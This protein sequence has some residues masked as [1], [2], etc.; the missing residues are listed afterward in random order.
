MQKQGA[1]ASEAPLRASSSALEARRG[2]GRRSAVARR[3][4][5]AACP[6][7]SEG[8]TRHPRCCVR[9]SLLLVRLREHKSSVIKGLPLRPALRLCPLAACA[10]RISRPPLRA[11]PLGAPA[12]RLICGP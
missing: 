12:I 11:P 6:L 1:R 9:A 2:Q 7:R 8:V 4:T 10:S 3:R 5:L